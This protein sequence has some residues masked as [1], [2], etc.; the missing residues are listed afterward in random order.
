MTI[1]CYTE[2]GADRKEPVNWNERK[3][4]LLLVMGVLFA[5]VVIAVI[6]T[7]VGLMLRNSN[8][9]SAPIE[10]AMQL[11]YNVTL[12]GAALRGFVSLLT[13]L[14]TNVS[15]SF[16]DTV[17]RHYIFFQFEAKIPLP[18]SLESLE[19]CFTNNVFLFQEGRR[20][21][22]TTATTT[23]TTNFPGETFQ[24][25][26]S[27]C[28]PWMGS[29]STLQLQQQRPQHVAVVS[30]FRDY[31]A[32]VLVGNHNTNPLASS[33]QSMDG[34]VAYALYDGSLQRSHHP[35]FRTPMNRTTND[36][37]IRG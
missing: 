26:L 14:P 32:V 7:F 2:D 17:I 36:Y 19:I 18:E 30:S 3:S 23:S 31:G 1:E 5:L 34:V 27:V 4:R 15:F 9:E 10:E 8:T 16:D 12:E 37:D 29:H 13:S 6:A 24:P 21:M 11:V 25:F 20:Q 28:F 33:S 22:N 35:T